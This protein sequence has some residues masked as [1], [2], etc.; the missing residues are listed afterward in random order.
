VTD[1]YVDAGLLPL[2]FHRRHYSEDGSRA[3]FRKAVYSFHPNED[4]A[5]N[6]R[7]ETMGSGDMGAFWGH[8]YEMRVYSPGSLKWEHRPSR[9]D[10]Y[11]SVLAPGKTWGGAAGWRNLA[12][13]AT[14]NQGSLTARNQ[15][16]HGG[17]SQDGSSFI[18]AIGGGRALRE[19]TDISTTNPTMDL[20]FRSDLYYYETP[21]LRYLFARNNGRLKRIEL[22]GNRIELLGNGFND[23]LEQLTIRYETG[24]IP[25]DPEDPPYK[26]VRYTTPSRSQAELDDM[27]YLRII[28]GYGPALPVSEVQVVTGE[29]PTVHIHQAVKYEYKT[30]TSGSPLF[31][32]QNSNWVLE[33]IETY[34][35]FSNSSDIGVS[36]GLTLTKSVEYIHEGDHHIIGRVVLDH[37]DDPSGW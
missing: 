3:P 33:R 31:G 37:L 25:F 18:R 1:V 26:T 17:M 30:I 32:L 22:L 16:I 13:L 23:V 28:Y 24:T 9:G 20:G 19:P 11:F 34:H 14:E 29:E 12:S 36:D 10:L 27:P 8:T 5:P 7:Q 15:T 21:N 2:V 35:D 4:L 6:N